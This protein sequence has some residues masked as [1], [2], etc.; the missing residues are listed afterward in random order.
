MG[1]IAVISNTQ[2]SFPVEII[3][4]GGTLTTISLIVTLSIAF[5]ISDSKYSNE[6]TSDML[7]V[8]TNPF[9]ITFAAIVVFKIFLII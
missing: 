1:I 9:L 7:G 8:C 5:L 2:T 3:S 4:Q 6:W